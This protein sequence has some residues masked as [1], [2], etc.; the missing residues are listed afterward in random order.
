MG[1]FAEVWIAASVYA[2]FAASLPLLALAF[3][4]RDGVTRAF[5]TAA[6]RLNAAIGQ[7][8]MWLALAMVLL[9]VTIVVM[10]YVFGAGHIALQEA[11]LYMHGSL[12]LACAGYALYRDA[13]VRVD[14]VYRGAA[15]RTKAWIDIAGFYL[16]VLPVC[17]VIFYVCFPYVFRSWAI[18]ERSQ[19]SSGIPYLYLLK[20]MILVL[21]GLLTL[22]GAAMAVRGALHLRDPRE[23]RFPGSAEAA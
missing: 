19:S 21:P 2:G 20:T 6:D 11:M 3:L 7:G 18:L 22:Q 1:R 10:R 4:G 23:K 9:Q 15:T 12:F 13:H 8:F 17:G 16:F 14:L 5:A